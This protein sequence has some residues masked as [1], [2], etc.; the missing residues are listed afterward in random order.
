M[1]AEFIGMCIALCVASWARSRF[2]SPLVKSVFFFVA[3]MAGFL[4]AVGFGFAVV[5]IAAGGDPD[6]ARAPARA[7]GAKLPETLGAVIVASIAGLVSSLGR[8]VGEL[9]K[10]SK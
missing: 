9:S 8:Q 3:A 10:K 6:S 2:E 7:L 4:C 1:I 5:V